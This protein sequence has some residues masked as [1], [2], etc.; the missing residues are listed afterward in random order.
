MTDLPNRILVIK[1]STNGRQLLIK[2]TNGE[3]HWLKDKEIE[4]DYGPATA[5]ENDQLAET[6]WPDTLGL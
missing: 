3:E 5:E 4:N 6:H 1:L 2:D